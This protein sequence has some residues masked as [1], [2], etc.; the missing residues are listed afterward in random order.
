VVVKAAGVVPSLVEG[1]TAKEHEPM[2]DVHPAHHAASSWKEFLI[3]IAT[4]VLGL[5]I[6]IALEQTV[7]PVAEG[8]GAFEADQTDAAVFFAGSLV[9]M[10]GNCRHSVP[11]CHRRAASFSK[12]LLRMGEQCILVSKM[13][14]QSSRFISFIYR[15]WYPVAASAE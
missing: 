4:I 8:A 13:T 1:E 11:E 14:I 3:H 9:G 15:Y 2:L 6:A 12:R 10:V 5:L 7:E